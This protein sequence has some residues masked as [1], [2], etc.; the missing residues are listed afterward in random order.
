MAYLYKSV[1]RAA[2][3][4]HNRA[5]TTREEE[6]IYRL[7]RLCQH[8]YYHHCR[9]SS[10][11]FRHQPS[12]RCRRHPY[13]HHRSHGCYIV[14]IAITIIVSATCFSGAM[15]IYKTPPAALVRDSK[16]TAL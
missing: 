7:R 2:Y 6:N 4:S 11:H 13:R 15:L 14:L 8:S 3:H 16:V 12:C 1:T 10:S 5:Y 9:R